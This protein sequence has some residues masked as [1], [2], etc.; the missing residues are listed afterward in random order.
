M[1]KSERY[2]DRFDVLLLDMGN[3]FMFDC[4]LFGFEDGLGETYA[5][6]GG[7]L[8]SDSQVHE[9]LSTVFKQMLAYGKVEANYESVKSVYHYIER[10]ESAASL[11][12]DELALLEKVFTEHEIGSIPDEYA[13]IIRELSKTHRLGIISDIWAPSERFFR[14]LEDTGI[15]ELFE[16]IVFSSDVGVIKPSSKIFA[17][18][19][20][21]LDVDMSK[22]VYIGDSFRRD[23]AGAKNFGISAIWIQQGQSINFDDVK[24][25]LVVNDLCDLLI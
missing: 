22:V 24:P 4:D 5:E 20:E 25:D 10:V 11:P 16:V 18:A 6:F 2:I 8:L 17:K 7:K 9:I 14:E 3:T 1:T 23:V 15:K 21:G 13:D 12:P 19:M